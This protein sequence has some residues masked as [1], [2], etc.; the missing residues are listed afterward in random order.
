MDGSFVHLIRQFDSCVS[1]IIKSSF[2]K[3]FK[4][5]YVFG[6]HT[7]Q[8]GSYIFRRRSIIFCLYLFGNVF[9][10]CI[11]LNSSL[12]VKQSFTY[13]FVPLCF[14]HCMES[15]IPTTFLFI[16]YVYIFIDTESSRSEFETEHDTPTGF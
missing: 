14:Y 12:N 9:L 1:R 16:T 5:F 13:F 3:D 7:F 6:N 8:S 15:F 2:F 4:S 10:S 11:Q